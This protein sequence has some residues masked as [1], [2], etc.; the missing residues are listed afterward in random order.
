MS[1]IID[2]EGKKDPESDFIVVIS[3]NATI[4]SFNA[5]WM[6]CIVTYMYYKHKL[7]V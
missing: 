1:D 3:V 6:H 5:F 7:Y 2:L 4:K